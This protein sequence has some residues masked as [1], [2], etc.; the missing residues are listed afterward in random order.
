MR[1]SHSVVIREKPP[2]KRRH[3][4]FSYGC[5]S[6]LFWLTT[7]F[8][9]SDSNLIYVFCVD[10]LIIGE[11]VCKPNYCVFSTSEPRD[12]GLCTEKHV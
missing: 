2:S 10:T 9:N 12:E 8:H 5:K 11:L 4:L 7:V 1:V 3:I 6:G